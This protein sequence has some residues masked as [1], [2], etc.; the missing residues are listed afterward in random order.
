MYFS[1]IRRMMPLFAFRQRLASSA[2]SPSNF[3]FAPRSARP[4]FHERLISSRPVPASQIR[5]C[6][7]VRS[8]HG[9]SRSVPGG[10]FF[11]AS[12]WAATPLQSRRIHRGMSRKPPTMASAPLRSDLSGSATS[13][14]GSIP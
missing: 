8:F 1:I 3:V 4:R 9:V 7:G 2:R 13:F 5:F 11:F 10:S 6:C 14:T 12:A